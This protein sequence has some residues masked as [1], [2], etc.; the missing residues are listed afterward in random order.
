MTTVWLV[1]IL[2]LTLPSEYRPE[3]SRTQPFPIPGPPGT[4]TSEEFRSW[5]APGGKALYLFYWT[6]AARDLGPMVVVSRSPA[7]VAGQDTEIIETSMFMG[8]KQRVLATHLGFEDQKASAMI[9]AVGVG[10]DEFESLLA[11]ITR[12]RANESDRSR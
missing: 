3:S 12:S 11:G 5:A 8:V 9:Y 7:R 2:S 10:H 4:T 6:P 1:A